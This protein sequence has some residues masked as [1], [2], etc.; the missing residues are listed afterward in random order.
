MDLSLKR[1]GNEFKHFPRWWGAPSTRS[2]I[3]RARS[4][5]WA[6]Q[7]NKFLRGKLHVFCEK[8]P[9]IVCVILASFLLST[10]ELLV[11]GKQL[12]AFL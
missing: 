9:M 2:Q 11:S 7:S 6:L 8:S 10:R 1:S 12:L 5:A 3:G 4:V